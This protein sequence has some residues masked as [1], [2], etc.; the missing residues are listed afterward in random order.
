[1]ENKYIVLYLFKYILKYLKKIFG[2]TSGH[3]F[4]GSAAARDRTHFV[5]TVCTSAP[6]HSCKISNYRILQLFFFVFISPKKERT[7]CHTTIIHFISNN[8][9]YEKHSFTI[10]S[11][12]REKMNNFAFAYT[13]PCSQ[14]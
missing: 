8:H 7:L 10:T 13:T 12:F 2:P 1:M 9:P 3:T 14:P 11:L 5:L 4:C 6:T